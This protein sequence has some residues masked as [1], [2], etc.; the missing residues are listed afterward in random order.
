MA[1]EET[2]VLS[3][4]KG[5]KESGKIKFKEGTLRKQLKLKKSDKFTKTELNKLSKLEIGSKFNFH[6]NSFK[7]T[8][9]MK[10]RIDLGKTLL[11]FKKKK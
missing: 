10:E 3:K 2:I 8:K 6:G 5:A 1:K 4:R 11:G 7:M 9:L